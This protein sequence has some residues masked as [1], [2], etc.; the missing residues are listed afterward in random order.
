M[1]SINII[2]NIVTFK[3]F[4]Y[5]NY[6]TLTLLSIII[7]IFFYLVHFLYILFYYNVFLHL[8]LYTIYINTMAMY[9]LPGIKKNYFNP[10]EVIIYKREELRHF[11]LEAHKEVF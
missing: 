1:I 10:H 7:I 2:N 11:V 3:F 9:S 4:L 5:F 6:I 8:N